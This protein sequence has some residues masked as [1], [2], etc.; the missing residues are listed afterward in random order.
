M[1]VS[2]ATLIASLVLLPM[3][4]ITAGLVGL[5]TLRYG[6]LDGAIVLGASLSIAAIVSLML[7]HTFDLVTLFAATVGV[8][9]LLLACVL[10]WSRSQSVTLAAT[11]ALG[12]LTFGAIHLFAGDPLQWWQA[13]SRATWLRGAYE[14]GPVLALEPQAQAQVEQLFDHL[15][16]VSY[17]PLWSMTLAMIMLL[18]ARWWH[19]TLD[20]PGGFGREFRALRLDGRVA[21]VTIALGVLALMLGGAAHGLAGWLLQLV[22]ALYA[23]QGVALVHAV[24]RQRKASAGWLVT[25]YTLLLV[26]TPVAVIGLVVVGFSDAWINYRARWQTDA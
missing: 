25:M 4:A 2:A 14:R 7:A 26:L 1:L 22:L 10:R 3:S 6:P 15:I 16:V 5:V 9:V 13:F 20:N 12:G 23:F 21:M 19:A 18:I 8:P 11:G 24:V 17:F